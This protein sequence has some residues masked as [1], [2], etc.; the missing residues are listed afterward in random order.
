MEINSL[1]DVRVGEFSYPTL[2]QRI[3]ALK[4]GHEVGRKT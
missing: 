3:N 2:N 1:V 4:D